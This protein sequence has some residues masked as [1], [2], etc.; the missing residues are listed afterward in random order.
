MIAD[1]KKRTTGRDMRKVLRDMDTRYDDDTNGGYYQSYP[2]YSSGP[3]HYESSQNGYPYGYSSYDQPQ[4][5]DRDYRGYSPGPGPVPASSRHSRQRSVE[6]PYLSRR[7]QGQYS[8]YDPQPSE[9]PST[10]YQM[11]SRG[12]SK[13]RSYGEDLDDDDY[14]PPAPARRP[15]AIGQGL[16]RSKGFSSAREDYDHFEVC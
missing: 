6:N 9:P 14:Y 15:S 12:P 8:S 3:N 7:T 16:A 4:D 5:R 2:S 11:S 1:L 10:R 13:F